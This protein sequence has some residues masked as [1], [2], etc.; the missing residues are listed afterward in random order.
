MDTMTKLQWPELPLLHPTMGPP[1][2]DVR[3]VYQKT[4]SYAYDPGLGET[5]ICRSA[6]AYVDGDDG[7]LLYRGYPIE[8]LVE[9]CSFLEICWL[10]LNGDLPSAAQ[11]DRFTWDITHHTMVNEQLHA[12]YRGFRRDAHPMAVMCGVVGA[13]AAFYHDGLDIFDPQH[14]M[15]AAHRLIAKMPTIAAMAYKYSQGQPLVY[16]RN[17]LGYAEN[18][19]NMLFSVPCEAYRVPEAAAR[20]LEAIL[21]THADHEQNASTSAMR[22]VG[23]TRANPYACTAAAIAALWGPLHGGANQGVLQTLAEIGSADRIPEILRRAKDKNDPFRLMGFGHR[24]YKSYD[25]RAKVLRRSCYEVLEA[26]GQRDDP[27]LELA[28]ELERVVLAD[29]YFIERKLY[30]NVDFYSGIILRALGL[31]PAMFTPVFAVARTVG[32]V[33]HWNEMITDPQTRLTRPRQL[34]DGPTE[35]PVVPI[36]ERHA[37]QPFVG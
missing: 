34:Y 36:A 1:M 20:A 24:V 32:W 12:I 37:H 16:P 4:G 8:A 26:S 15:I 6:I 25:P 11:L 13:L 33:A 23:S 27:L 10:V 31:P 17:D 18:F 19:L 21:I 30:P 29:D 14:R 22:F 9:S 2:V 35:R 28:M 7:V 3:S 5:G